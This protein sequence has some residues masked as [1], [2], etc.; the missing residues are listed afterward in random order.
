MDAK[1]FYG[2][3]RGKERSGLVQVLIALQDWNLDVAA[4]EPMM[5]ISES[6]EPIAPTTFELF[7][8]GESY[9]LAM[10]MSQVER[11]YGCITARYEKTDDDGRVSM[12]Y[13]IENKGATINITYDRIGVS[14]GWTCVGNAWHI[15]LVSGP[16][17]S[18]FPSH[19]VDEP[20]FSPLK[21]SAKKHASIQED[22]GLHIL[23]DLNPKNP[24]KLDATLG[25]D[26][27]V[28]CSELLSKKVPMLTLWQTVKDIFYLN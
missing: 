10:A 16:W 26:R 1:E 14:H 2:L 9:N 23:V 19:D 27:K 28:P 6:D 21:I 24:N 15:N 4:E 22:S 3:A 8:R 11:K 13:I 5:W 18:V 12:N 25:I 7:V 17:E 20:Y